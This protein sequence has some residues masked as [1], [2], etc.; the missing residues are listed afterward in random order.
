MLTRVGIK[1]NRTHGMRVRT[2][3]EERSY[4]VV[5]YSETK[6]KKDSADLLHIARTSN[7]KP[8]S[9]CH[10]YV[11][12]HSSEDLFCDALRKTAPPCEGFQMVKT[13]HILLQGRSY[14]PC[15]LYK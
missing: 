13:L 4:G 9:E 10:L 5:Q 2:V 11:G 6:K 8:Q 14:L 1:A 3:K 7:R 15:N 12:Q